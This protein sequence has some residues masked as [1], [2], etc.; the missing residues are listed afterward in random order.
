MNI[1]KVYIKSLAEFRPCELV[2]ENT[3]SVVLRV[4]FSDGKKVIKKNK[5]NLV[6]E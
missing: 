6:T 1:T 2:K 4:D 5:K 3:L